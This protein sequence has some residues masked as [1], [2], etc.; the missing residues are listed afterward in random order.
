[1]AQNATS[2]TPFTGQEIPQSYLELYAGSHFD[3][4]FPYTADATTEHPQRMFRSSI[5]DPHSAGAGAPYS[6][7]AANEALLRAAIAAVQTEE[8]R[9]TGSTISPAPDPVRRNIQLPVEGRSAT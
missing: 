1:M 2:G 6:F 5:R 7:S 8:M 3:Q 9:H 4:N